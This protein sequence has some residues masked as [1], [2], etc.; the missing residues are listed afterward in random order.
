[1]NTLSLP[2]AVTTGSAA[3]A[4]F[5]RLASEL[6]PAVAGS[7]SLTVQGVTGAGLDLVNRFSKGIAVHQNRAA[8]VRENELELGGGQPGVERNGYR[9]EFGG[10][11]GQ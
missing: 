3:S 6:L 11:S 9:A 1:M 2:P 7:H 5:S 10:C 8:T 4:F